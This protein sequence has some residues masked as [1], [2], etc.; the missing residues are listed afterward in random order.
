MKRIILTTAD[1]Q[2]L[3]VLKVFLMSMRYHGNDYPIRADLINY[4]DD[5]VGRLRNLYP[6]LEIARIV[7]PSEGELEQ[8]LL[9]LMHTRPP[10]MW[11]ALNE[12]W[13]QILS[14]DCDIIIR[15]RID[16]MWDGVAPG[17]FKILDKGHRQSDKGRLQGGVYIFGNSPGIREYYKELMDLIGAEFGFWDGQTALYTLL[18]KYDKKITFVGLERKYNDDR[19]LK[20]DKKSLVW[21]CKHGRLGLKRFEREFEFYLKKANEYYGN[22]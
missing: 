3:D 1:V 10:Q 6:N 8:R 18:K 11:K 14:M 17:V 13:D 19:K 9:R 4:T 16:G 20:M 5:Q 7:I 22:K 15:G 2:Y 12:D 21:H